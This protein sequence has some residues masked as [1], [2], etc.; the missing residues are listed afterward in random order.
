MFWRAI[1]LL[2]DTFQKAV[3]IQTVQPV[4][5]FPFGFLV[6]S[7]ASCCLS[8]RAKMLQSCPTLC[9]PLD[10]V[11][12]QAPLSKG[13]SRQEYWSGLPFP[14]PGDLPRDRTG[15]SYVSCVGLQVFSAPAKL[16]RWPL[17]LCKHLPVSVCLGSPPPHHL[18]QLPLPY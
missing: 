18:H 8:V 15:I 9:N 12:C 16:S 13:F 14:S 2:Y 1:Y 10:C 17:G 3:C 5:Q 7:G 11:A 4:T 6:S